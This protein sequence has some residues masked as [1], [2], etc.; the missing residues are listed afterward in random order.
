LTYY[1]PLLGGSR[2]VQN[3]L[4]MGQGEGLDRAAHW[5]NQSPNAKEITAG[6]WYESAFAPYFQGRTVAL[7]K[8]IS[9]NRVVF[10][11]NGI[12]R[13]KPEPSVFAYLTA[14]Q[15]LYT[16]QLHGV[17]YVRVYP[18]PVPLPEDL[19]NIQ[20]PL[21][22]SFGKQIRLLGYDLNR[23]ELKPGE[24]LLVT[25]YWKFLEPLPPDFNIS[26]SLR[27]QDGNFQ[28]RSDA[29]LLAGYLPVDQIVPGTVVRDVHKLTTVPNVLPGHYRLEVGCFSPNKGQA[30]EA[31]DAAGNAQGSQAVIGEVEVVGQATY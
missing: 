15:P 25:F 16:V 21:S 22:L 30:L 4:M 17:D 27:N 11:I 6:V 10:Y 5:L 26:V 13:Q 9:V 7:I 24:K 29:P 20:V 31:R 3:L 28:N 1:N 8:W 18:G 2:A 12:Q 14:E 19:K 23:S